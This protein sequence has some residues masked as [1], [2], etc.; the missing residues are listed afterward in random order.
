MMS[1]SVGKLHKWT[2]EEDP[3]RGCAM[4]WDEKT[5]TLITDPN[6]ILKSRTEDWSKVWQCGNETARQKTCEAVRIA[7][8]RAAEE[9]KPSTMAA[10]GETIRQV[11]STFKKS[12]SIGLDL[13]AFSELALCGLEDLDKLALLHMNWDTEMVAPSQ[14]LTNLLNMIPK[15][16]RGTGV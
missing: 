13:W 9:G 1:E 10:C 11:S 15:K 3:T 4:Q 6:V 16:K 8:E 14:W 5:N 7:R 12:T 2:K